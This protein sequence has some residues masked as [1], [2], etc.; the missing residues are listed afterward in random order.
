[1]MTNT[2]VT[3]LRFCG[4]YV[5]MADALRPVA[6]EVIDGLCSLYDL[7][8]FSVYQFYSEKDRC[9]ADKLEATINRIRQT[10]QSQFLE[11]AA[12]GNGGFVDFSADNFWGLGNRVVAIESVLNLATQMN[13][14][15]PYL[16]ACLPENKKLLFGKFY[17]TSVLGAPV[18]MR[19]TILPPVTKLYTSVGFKPYHWYHIT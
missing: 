11:T 14:L 2:A 7:Y 8:L 17:A 10:S 3:V 13:N 15:R 18:E 6:A 16:D 1:M 4:Q 12:N 5:Q 19:N 9:G